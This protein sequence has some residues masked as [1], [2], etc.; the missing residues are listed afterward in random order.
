MSHTGAPLSPS[1]I[2]QTKER[3]RNNHP[4]LA[5]GLL[6]PLPPP[7]LSPRQRPDLHLA[8]LPRRRALWGLLGRA[9]TLCS[10]R[11]GEGGPHPFANWQE[12]LLAGQTLAFGGYGLA[13]FLH[14]A[15]TCAHAWSRLAWRPSAGPMVRGGP[16]GRG[17]TWGLPLGTGGRCGPTHS[18]GC[19]SLVG[20]PQR[21]RPCDGCPPDGPPSGRGGLPPRLL[22]P[23]APWVT[24]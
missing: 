24:T 3:K 13:Q 23:R 17:R 20:P 6:S 11:G 19:R 22:P 7:D 4:R 12:S 1:H 10:L 8:L 16:L 21:A 9:A 5:R 14:L 15:T 2:C 18:T